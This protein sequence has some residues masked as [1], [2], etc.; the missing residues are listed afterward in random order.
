VH[1]GRRYVTLGY[2]Q[3]LTPLIQNLLLTQYPNLPFEA[4][5]LLATQPFG[6]VL[7][8]DDLR[9]H[10]DDRLRDDHPPRRTIDVPRGTSPG[11]VMTSSVDP[12]V[13]FVVGITCTARIVFPSSA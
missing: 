13:K 10:R 4:A 3:L 11:S 8:H 5:E 6:P 12:I 1:T 9:V 7:H 2:Y